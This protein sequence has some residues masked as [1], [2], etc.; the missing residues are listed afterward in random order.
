[1]NTPAGTNHQTKLFWINCIKVFATLLVVMQHSISYEW[2]RLLKTGGSSWNIINLVFMLTKIGVPVFIMCSGMGMLQ[3][4]RSIK[5]IYL[6]NSKKLILLY[7]AWMLVFG[8]VD[9][10]DLIA[11][12]LATPGTIIN[13]FLKAVLF[14]KYHTWFIIT[15]LGLYAITP[16][17][18][19]IAKN[20]VLLKYFLLLSIIFTIILPYAGKIEA[21]S[22]VNT[23]IQNANMHFVLGYSLYFMMGY[24]LSS[25]ELNKTRKLITCLIFIFS[26]TAAL[27]LSCHQRASIEADCQTIYN[28]FSLLG[29]FMNTSF[30]LLFRILFEAAKPASVMEQVIAILS[31]CGIGIYLFHPL[32]LFL[33]EDIQGITCILGGFIIWGLTCAIMLIIYHL[34]IL[35]RIFL[36]KN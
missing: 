25:V 35:S 31:T 34:P 9:M 3:K 36:G 5:S 18:Y 26:A 10:Y 15:L 33:V 16:L 7:V 28:E 21:L 4:K 8:V 1:M 27:V 24:Y 11:S 13:V 32:I 23:V 12:E 14:G 29:F 30:F 6:N 17:L 19:E 20:K 2:V 22:R